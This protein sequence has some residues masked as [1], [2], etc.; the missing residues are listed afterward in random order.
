[1]CHFECSPCIDE[2]SRYIV[3]VTLST[4]RTAALREARSA[5]PRGRAGFATYT[6]GN[7]SRGPGARAPRRAPSSLNAAVDR[8][9][10][11]MILVDPQPRTLAMICDDATRARLEALGP[12]VVHEDGPMPDATVEAASPRGD[13]DRRPDRDAGRAARAGAEAA[14]D[15]ERRGQL[16]AERGL[17]GGARARRARAQ[18]EP[19]V[20]AAGGGDGA[21][22][23]DRPRARDQRGRPRDAGRHRGL[24]ARRQRRVVPDQRRAGRDRRLRRPRAR[25]APA[26]GAVPL[27]REGLRPVGAGPADR[28]RRRAAR[29]AR[30]HPRRAR[31]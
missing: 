24:R 2:T 28:A 6:V 7:P 30:R 29:L 27:P 9:P 26:A 17:R 1:M 19:G 10:R 16:P 8:I 18:R 25:A 5:S 13:R 21:R 3:I 23:G 20:R 12:L 14:G 22:D 31:R 11:P 4:P 15:R